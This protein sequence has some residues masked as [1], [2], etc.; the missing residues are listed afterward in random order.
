MEGALEFTKGT[1]VLVPE[2]LRSILLTGRLDVMIDW[3]RFILEMK[4]KR[5]A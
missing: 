2:L 3:K 4:K 1:L 5:K